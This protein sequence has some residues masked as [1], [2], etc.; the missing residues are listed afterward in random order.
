MNTHVSSVTSIKMMSYC[1]GSVPLLRA[2]TF[3]HVSAR[4]TA[5]YITGKQDSKGLLVG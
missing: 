3:S 4:Q 2:Q 1:H 5:V